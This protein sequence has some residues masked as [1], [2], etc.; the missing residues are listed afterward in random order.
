MVQTYLENFYDKHLESIVPEY[1]K[2]DKYASKEVYMATEF[3]VMKEQLKSL[4][5]FQDLYWVIWCLVM[6]K[7][8]LVNPASGKVW[9]DDDKLLEMLEEAYQFY[10]PYAK[11]RLE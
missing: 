7:G 8:P 3:P 4:V 5:L 11:M 2:Y 10:I 9:E 6:T 1:E